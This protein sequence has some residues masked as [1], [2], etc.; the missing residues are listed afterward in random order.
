MEYDDI[1]RRSL[2]IIIEN[3]D[4]RIFHGTIQPN[5]VAQ[6]LM[7]EFNRGNLYAQTVGNPEKMAVQISTRM[8][9]MSGGQT[10]L[11]ITIQKVEDGIMVELGQQAWLG[12]AASLGQ[13]AL[14]AL[15]NPF[16][17]LGRLDDLAQDIE[18]IQLTDNVWKS[19]DRVI[20]ALGASHALSE[21]LA[22]IACEYCGTANPIGEGNCI[23]CGAPLGEVQPTT[24]PNCGFV[25]TSKETQCPNCHKTL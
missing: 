1:C 22:R 5:D 17:L 7:A 14:T 3:M 15:R 19:I 12:V 10:A 25:I 6:A 8:G 13:T 23:T 16:S 4:R 24:C 21:K 9:A 18:N 20:T 11:T 2:R